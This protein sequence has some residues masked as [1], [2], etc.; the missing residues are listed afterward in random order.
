MIK[1]EF[2]FP[3]L[4]VRAGN[5]LSVVPGF[6]NVVP[7]GRRCVVKQISLQ[8]DDARSFAEYQLLVDRSLPSRFI[9]TEHTYL[10]VG[11]P[12]SVTHPTSE[13]LIETVHCVSRPWA[14][15]LPQCPD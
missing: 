4:E 11:I 1:P 15:V 14:C 9:L 10:S 6:G 3:L 8:T 2:A 5:E 12:I 13:I 7:Y